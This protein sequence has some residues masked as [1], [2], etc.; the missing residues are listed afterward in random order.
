MEEF[1][2]FEEWLYTEKLRFPQESDDQSYLLIK[3]FCFAEK[4]ETPGLQNAALDAIRDRATGQHV[5]TE[6]PKPTS[7]IHGKSQSPFAFTPG[8]GFSFPTYQTKTVTEKPSANYLP[9]ATS[10][11]IHY[12]YLHTP[13]GSP[14][15][16]LLADIFAYNVK[17]D[18]LDEDLQSFPVEFTVDVLLINMKRLPLRMKE[19][20][21]DFD[22]DMSKYYIHKSSNAECDKRQRVFG[23][24][25]VQRNDSEVS[26]RNESSVEAGVPDDKPP[27]QIVAVSEN[28]A[29]VFGVPNG[30]SSSKGKKKG[31]K[32][33]M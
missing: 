14:L 26:P 3:L 22:V 21:A 9:P 8:S 25:Q 15:R 18:T 17:A 16:K 28:D 30:A 19:E 7:H 24:V 5:S 11:A 10:S 6:S 29:R 1:K 32:R 23:D 20:R 13:E 31:L 33:S 12:A 2:L 27:A 4:V